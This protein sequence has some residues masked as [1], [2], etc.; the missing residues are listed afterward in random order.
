MEK[1]EA[2]RKQAH[3]INHQNEFIHK[4]G[5]GHGV[6]QHPCKRIIRKRKKNQSSHNKWAHNASCNSFEMKYKHTNRN[7]SKSE[8]NRANDAMEFWEWN[9]SQWVN[10]NAAR[11]E[12]MR[13]E[14]NENY[15]LILCLG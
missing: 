6:G 3:F 14:V 8:N 15:N 4:F 11:F 1:E 9:G 10:N 13:K 12:R 2:I 7:R 5:G